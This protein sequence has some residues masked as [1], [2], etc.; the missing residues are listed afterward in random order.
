MV[1][2]SYLGIFL[3]AQ[4][5]LVGRRRGISK[6]QECTLGAVHC[7]KA[8]YRNG[9]ATSSPPQTNLRPK[10]LIACLA[11]LL[12]S[13][14]SC[15]SPPTWPPPHHREYEPKD[16]SEQSAKPKGG[17]RRR[18]KYFEA[19]E[20][21]VHCQKER[22]RTKGAR[23]RPMIPPDLLSDEEPLHMSE[24]SDTENPYRR[25]FS[26]ESASD[27][28][29][30]KHKELRKTGL[31]SDPVDLEDTDDSEHEPTSLWHTHP[32]A[33]GN[34]EI[35]D[36][37]DFEVLD[38]GRPDHQDA[39]RNV[40]AD[41]MMMNKT[42]LE[43]MQEGLENEWEDNEAAD[44]DEFDPNLNDEIKDDL[45][46][47]MSDHK[48]TTTFVGNDFETPRDGVGT[49]AQFGFAYGITC[50]SAG[51][52]VVADTE[53]NKLK[54]ISPSGELRTLA[55]GNVEGYKDGR[56]ESALFASPFGVAFDRRTGGFYVADTNNRAIRRI[57]PDFQDVT[58]FFD[59]S[60]TPRSLSDPSCLWHVYGIAVNAKGDVY[61]SDCS[62]GVIIKI[63]PDG[64]PSHVA[65]NGE[66]GHVDGAGEQAEFMFP[67]GLAFDSYDNLYVGDC[68]MDCDYGHDKI[69]KISPSHIVTT[70]AGNV[71]SGLYC[72]SYADGPRDVAEFHSPY[73]IAVDDAGN[74]Y[75]GDAM[76]HVVRMIA[77]DGEVGTISGVTRMA[78]CEDGEA[79]LSSFVS[80]LGIAV[81]KGDLYVLDTNAARIRKVHNMPHW[82]YRHRAADPVGHKV[83]EDF[84]EMMDADEGNEKAFE[85]LQSLENSVNFRNAIDSLVKQ[86]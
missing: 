70:Y 52:L 29:D 43:A 60:G 40:D 51:N 39:L 1:G 10:R 57:S 73:G 84:K 72:S 55:G 81:V 53:E 16:P 48:Q 69:R 77:T 19:I 27:L 26:V 86:R 37:K 22:N 25:T 62:R 79:G 44:L 75:T 36:P 80:P 7:E 12:F 11:G 35:L 65:G 17:R 71:Y 85:E 54:M 38:A 21:C 31:I 33:N 58:T 2:G 6:S 8:G 50:D 83:R 28:L 9:M 32:D 30:E 47:R 68:V 82:S 3:L 78:G 18:M 66:R 41:L 45:L 24:D 63:S 61:V 42:K 67:Y 15:S 46:P 5:L 34:F 13:L 14:A 49:N 23:W 56:A 59:G 20:K 76:N 64:V 4:V 74:V